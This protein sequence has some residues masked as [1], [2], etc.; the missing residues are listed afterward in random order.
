MTRQAEKNRKNSSNKPKLLFVITQGVWGGAQKYVFSH[1]KALSNEFDVFVAIGEP[2][3]KKDLQKAIL[4]FNDTAHSPIQL[5]SLMHVRRAIHPIHDIAALF[6]LRTLISALA[7]AVVHLNSSKAG[8]LGSLSL[9]RKQKALY[10]VH[11]WVFAEPHSALVNN[12]FRFLER[13]AAK[14]RAKAGGAT[15]LLSEQEKK[16]GM[17]V[18]QGT[19]SHIIPIGLEP[20][21]FLSKKD[22]R[23]LLQKTLPALSD[24][25]PWIGCVANMYSTKG[26]DILIKAATAVK[27]TQIIIIGEG[28]ERSTLE[29][30]ITT[31]KLAKTVFLTGSLPQA[32]TLMKAFDRAVIPSRKEGLPYT[33]LEWMQAEVPVIA[34]CVG[35]I[36]SV[37]GNGITGTLIEPNSIPALAEALHS[38][39]KTTAE[40]ERAKAV[41]NTYTSEETI[42]QLRQLVA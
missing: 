23:I 7:P 35:G 17:S 12:L 20:I 16:L 40:V 31:N 2:T 15:I 38:T 37:L 6:E 14:A 1:A 10:T 25:R 42:A 26:L 8:I 41:A 5:I 18:L 29:S 9:P 34:T 28:P 22:A 32:A 27:N 4:A 13:R 30:L 36:P 11:G 33:I 21:S 3:G 19:Q 24:D 39:K